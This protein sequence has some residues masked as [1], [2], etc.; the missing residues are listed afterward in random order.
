MSTLSNGADIHAG[1]ARLGIAAALLAVM[2][3]GASLGLAYS[4]VTGLESGLLMVGAALLCN[5][6]FFYSVIF[7]IWGLAP[8]RVGGALVVAL[9]GFSTLYCFGF[10]YHY[11]LYGQL[12][13]DPSIA[14]ALDSNPQEAAEFVWCWSTPAGR[15]IA[16]AEASPSARSLS[17]RRCSSVA[18]TSEA[19]RGTI[20]CTS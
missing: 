8:R 17:L 14:A 10:V 16:P 1:R 7:S 20:R 11:L 18:S 2:L 5:V 3:P 4:D 15:R 6:A 12:L 9:F 19:W 13:G